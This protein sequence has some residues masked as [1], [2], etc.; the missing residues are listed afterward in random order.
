[1]KKD[2]CKNIEEFHR[3]THKKVSCN[4]R[5]ACKGMVFEY[6]NVE[7]TVADA[8]MKT[9]FK[10]T[11]K[12]NCAEDAC[13]AGKFKLQGSAVCTGPGCGDN[14]RRLVRIWETITNAFTRDTSLQAPQRV[15]QRDS[16]ANRND[17]SLREPATRRVACFSG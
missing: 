4:Y 14:R 10:G 15:S 1:M 8:C 3:T 9:V 16:S 17:T 11:S 12:V 6:E 7:C 13:P 5:N 2:S